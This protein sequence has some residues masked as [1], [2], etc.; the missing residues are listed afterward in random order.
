MALGGCAGVN[1]AGYVPPGSLLYAGGPAGPVFY[2]AA[3]AGQSHQ[4]RAPSHYHAAE[5]VP[6]ARITSQ[7]QLP[8]AAVAKTIFVPVTAMPWLWTK[9]GT[10]QE[11]QF[12][13]PNGTPPVVV[14]LAASA[15]GGVSI[16]YTGGDISIGQGGPSADAAG[17]SGMSGQSGPLGA[18]P[19]RY[20]AGGPVN[21]GGLI[22]VF[23][24][25][26]GAIMAPPFAVA[27]APVTKQ[28]PPG[29]SRLQFGINDDVF[30]G[31][32]AQTRNTGG[33]TVRVS[34]DT[35]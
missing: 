23:T 29:A 33:F 18:Y 34:Q 28:I 27:A 15:G 16:Q 3:K 31:S 10:N 35:R 26:A 25:A 4:R 5:P 1:G 11:Y 21:L 30:G 12:G 22:G 17:Y 20:V 6:A 8:P 32:S 19:A 7:P 9:G 14:K 24:D 13:Y 2:P